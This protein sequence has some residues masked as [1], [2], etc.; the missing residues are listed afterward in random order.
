MINTI[1]KFLLSELLAT[2]LVIAFDDRSLIT[3]SQDNWRSPPILSPQPHS[4]SQT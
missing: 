2:Y 3:Q 4:L 1:W